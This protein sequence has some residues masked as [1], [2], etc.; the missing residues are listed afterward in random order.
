MKDIAIITFFLAPVFLFN[1]WF[2]VAILTYIVS[3]VTG[4]IAYL[5]FYDKTDF[6]H[7]PHSWWGG[8]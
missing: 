7:V 8:L 4:I 3:G 2:I 6:S 1:D 5:R